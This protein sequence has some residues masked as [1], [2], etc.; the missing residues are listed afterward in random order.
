M[1]ILKK[2]LTIAENFDLTNWKAEYD[3]LIEKKF[4][5]EIIMAKHELD[6]TIPNYEYQAIK[7][8]MIEVDALRTELITRC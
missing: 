4:R 3:M 1:P 8:R 6:G 7:R 5:M 2:E